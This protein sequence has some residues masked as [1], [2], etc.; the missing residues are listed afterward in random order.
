MARGRRRGAGGRGVGRS[1]YC[2]SGGA[3]GRACLVGVAHALGQE[4]RETRE[5]GSNVKTAL[6]MYKD[7]LSGKEC[8]GNEESAWWRGKERLGDVLPA[9]YCDRS[10]TRMLP[11]NTPT[12]E[13]HESCPPAPSPPPPRRHQKTA[14][15]SFLL[16]LD[17]RLLGSFISFF[18]RS[19]LPLLLSLLFCSLLSF[20]GYARRH[21]RMQLLDCIFATH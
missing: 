11:L 1:R 18:S 10:P 12:L 15:Y 14:A 20:A 21:R 2:G 17:T 7:V 5:C 13:E 4:I 3:E 19:F 16:H 8:V 6:I 9:L